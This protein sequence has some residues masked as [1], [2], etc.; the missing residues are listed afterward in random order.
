M[1]AER[2]LGPITAVAVQV[3]H[4]RWGLVPRAGEA[5]TGGGEGDV[6]AEAGRRPAPRVGPTADEAAAAAGLGAAATTAAIGPEA[7]V[8]IVADFAVLQL[9]FFLRG[10]PARIQR[11][12]RGHRRLRGRHG[13]QANGLGQ[14]APLGRFRFLRRAARP[15]PAP[16]PAPLRPAPTLARP[17]P[18][19][20]AREGGAR[21]VLGNVVR[22]AG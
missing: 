8:V 10:E 16:R 13:A 21:G 11:R 7:V 22:S 14:A 6:P 17:R 9:P 20:A 18:V 2:V 1:G 5:P 15:R 12:G 4:L 3:P 19:L